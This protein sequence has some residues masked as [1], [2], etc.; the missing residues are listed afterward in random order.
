[1]DAI[2]VHETGGPEVLRLE[3]VERPEPGPGDVLV[4]IEATGV[5]FI[6][7]YQR[8]GLYQVP[9]PTTPGSEAAG[10]VERVGP[11]VEGVQAGDRVVGAVM[12][13]TYAQYAL[14]AADRLVSLPAGIDTRQAA[15]VLLQGMTAHYLVHAT[16]PVQ[17]GDRVLVHAAAGGTGLLLVQMAKQLGAT[18]YATVSTDEKA[19]LARGAGA[20]EVILY[21]QRNVA[22]E[23]ARLTEGEG[24]HA[25]YDSVGQST[26]E[27][28]LAS[29]RVRGSLVLFGQSSG[30]VPPISPTILAGKALFLTRPSLGHYTRTRE[31]LLQRATAV[32]EAVASGTLQVRIGGTYPLREAAAAQTAL[33]GR[34]TT[35]K[36]LLLPA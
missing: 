35:G 5:N 9:L 21:T 4:R 10:T 34:G 3:Q 29:L 36:L 16:Y 13:G 33:A 2:R 11:G 8:T 27:G 18:V 20:D 26:F 32:L 24:V 7:I 23:V 25:V 19:D 12:Q 14:S 1:M 30:P 6:E 15:A 28:S 17:R 22:A 31:E